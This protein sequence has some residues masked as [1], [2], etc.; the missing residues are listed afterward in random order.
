MIQ[1]GEPMRA[2]NIK[3]GFWENEFLGACSRDARLLFMGLWSLAD[4]EGRLIWRPGRI[5]GKILPY[6]SDLTGED[7][8][9]LVGEL[10]AHQERNGEPMFLELYEVD[11]VEYLEIKNFKKHQ[12]PHKQERPSTLPDKFGTYSEPVRNQFGTTSEQVPNQHALESQNPRIPES[13]NPGILESLNEEKHICADKP[14]QIPISNI[15]NALAE[16]VSNAWNEMREGSKCADGNPLPSVSK[17]TK[18]RLVSLKDRA[19]EDGWLDSW[20]PALERIPQ[21]P[22]LCGHGD[23]GWKSDI[24]WFLKP[25]S[26]TK[27]LEGKY[28]G[29]AAVNGPK[30]PGE[31]PLRYDPITR[32][33]IKPGELE[34][35][36]LPSDATPEQV[37]EVRCRGAEWEMEHWPEDH[38]S[39]DHKKGQ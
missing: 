22:F 30:P 38:W 24:D 29:V 36:L 32:L 17:M 2:R 21:S 8:S 31:R 35:F 19:R 23:K 1:R 20:R 6:D 7:I 14:I 11:G 25:D 33:P 13:L 27:I 5:R 28:D 12:R 34:Y 18:K 3:P 9:R 26:V 4:R 10:A 15:P 37:E 39:E 16:D